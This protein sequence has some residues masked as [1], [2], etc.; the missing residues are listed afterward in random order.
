MKF[1][2][3][4]V[5]AIVTSLPTVIAAIIS[6]VVNSKLVAYKVEILGKKVE[7]HNSVVERTG[8]LE[9][10]LE[11]VWKRYDDMKLDIKD[12][13]QAQND[14]FKEILDILQNK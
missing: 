6:I 4:V 7:K 5:A 12:I 13:K 14:N 1:D 11:T 8:K 9:A 10:G 3:V 2:P